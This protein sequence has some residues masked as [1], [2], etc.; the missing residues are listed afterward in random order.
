MSQVYHSVNPCYERYLH[1]QLSF[2][3]A[4]GEFFK[5]LWTET[6]SEKFK[7]EKLNAT[8]TAKK[9]NIILYRILSLSQSELVSYY[10]ILYSDFFPDLRF[11]VFISYVLSIVKL[12]SGKRSRK[13]TSVED[14]ILRSFCNA[15][16]AKTVV[17]FYTLSV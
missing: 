10:R 5:I 16:S 13:L 4:S 3:I 14:L 17:N 8:F 7:F 11:W 2:K 6:G 12:I 1:L 9:S 15:D